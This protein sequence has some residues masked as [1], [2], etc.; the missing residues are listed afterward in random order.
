[1]GAGEHSRQMEQPVQETLGWGW[2]LPGCERGRPVLMESSESLDRVAK[3]SPAGCGSPLCIT[4]PLLRIGL[5]CDGG[6]KER[7]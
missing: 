3:G 5:H 2:P 6:V 1:M 7:F 4:R